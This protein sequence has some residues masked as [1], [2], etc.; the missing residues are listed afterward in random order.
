MDEHQPG[1]VTDLLNAWS[2]GRTDAEEALLEG[3]YTELRQL[4]QSYLRKERQ[5]H[6]LQATELINEAYLRFSKRGSSGW[7]DR[8]HFF[9]VAA[10]AMR[11]VLVDHAR[12]RGYKKRGSGRKALAL[13]QVPT[14]TERPHAEL[15]E[16]DD[17]LTALEKVDPRRA[18]VVELRFFG[19]FTNIET[20]EILACSRATVE[21]DWRLAQA[22]L[23]QE[24][25]AG[26][27]E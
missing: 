22:W 14:L 19:G 12:R 9:A 21:R 10:Q 1:T 20:A 27:S 25:A 23:Y 4:A 7:K 15:V 11:R 2:E 5:D 16:L 6:T 24:L 13:D 18:K 17:A 26:D 8:H 3:V